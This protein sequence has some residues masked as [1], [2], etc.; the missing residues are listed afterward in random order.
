MNLAQCIKRDVWNFA[1]SLRTLHD[2]QEI[3][4][5]S[6]FDEFCFLNPR[7]TIKIYIYHILIAKLVFFKYRIYSNCI[8]FILIP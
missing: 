7:V 4:N 1:N 2:I 6:L 3:S 5:S 8:D